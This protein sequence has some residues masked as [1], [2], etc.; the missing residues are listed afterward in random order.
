MANYF[1]SD[2]DL[3]LDAWLR[4]PTWDAVDA[5]DEAYFYLFV[6]ALSEIDLKPEADYL[7]GKI[8]QAVKDYHPKLDDAHVKDKVREAVRKVDIVFTYLR[9]DEYVG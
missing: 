8:V 5:R 2:V 7:V 4:R 1:N 3:A 9:A 6:R